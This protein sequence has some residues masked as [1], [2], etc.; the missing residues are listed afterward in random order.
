[1]AAV[2][3][4]E[5]KAPPMADSPGIEK[6]VLQPGQRRYTIA[7]PKGHSGDQ[8]VPLVLA[9]HFGGPVMPFYGKLILTGLVKPAL[10]ELAVIVAPDCTARDWTQPQS[11]ADVLAL[12]DSIQDIYSVDPQRTLVTGY[13]MG[14]QGAWYLAGR[15]QERFA[16]ALIMAGL[17]PSGVLDVEWKI[18]LY[19]IHSRQDEV[20]P[21]QPTKEAVKE[22]KAKGVSVEL[23]VLEGI[24][25]YETSRFVEP[26]RAARPWIE[27]VWQ[28]R[29]SNEHT[30]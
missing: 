17:P 25:H 26:L 22:L 14:G 10:G 8:P 3:T 24:T 9:L 18:P 30:T 12:L 19:V 21:L 5:R 23:V 4:V 11:E 1:M 7:I 28:T 20:M 13:S 2:N 27:G 6:R 15:H 16:A 29:R